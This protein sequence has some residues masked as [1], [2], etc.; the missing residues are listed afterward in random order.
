MIDSLD[1]IVLTSKNIK[2]CI[3]FYTK[4]LGMELEKNILNK[5][6]QLCLKFGKQKI[7]LHNEEEP[8]TPHA[9]NP[10]SGSV[11]LCFLSSLPLK[12]WKKILEKNNITIE[13]GPIK[14]IG[15]ISPIL[16][17]YVRDPDMNL[18]EIANKI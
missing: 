4:V 18:I 10:I 7:N 3:F 8:F 12:E 14:R 2:G 9:R 17:I 1:H 11:D 15:A 6:K 16:S 5:K 13:L